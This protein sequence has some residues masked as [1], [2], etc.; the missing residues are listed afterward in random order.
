MFELLLSLSWAD[1]SDS[2]TAWPELA[3][4][5]VEQ[6]NAQDHAIV[7]SVED[8]A[9]VPDIRGANLNASDWQNYFSKLYG[10]PVSNITWLQDGEATK[11]KVQ[12]A[13]LS[14]VNKSTEEGKVWFVFIGHGAPAKDGKDGMLVLADVQQDPQSLYD[15]SLSQE[16]VVKSL[17]K[18]KQAQ[19]LLIVDA[20]FSG[21]L[22]GNKALAEGL[23]PLIATTDLYEGNTTVLSA[24]RHNEFAGPLPGALPY[25]DRPAFSYLTLGG[26]LGWA[27]SDNDGTVSVKETIDYSQEALGVTLVGRT[28]EP[29]LFGENGDL[30]LG[31]GFAQGPD[32]AEI[33]RMSKEIAVKRADLL[34]KGKDGAPMSIAPQAKYGLSIGGG[35][36][37]V[38]ASYYF[39][40]LAKDRAIQELN[41]QEDGEWSDLG[42]KGRNHLTA[43][44]VLTG[45]GVPILAYGVK[46]LF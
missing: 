6:S 31:Q 7:V 1:A 3:I 28:Q 22:E 12:A 45:V 35:I 9:Y 10:I 38:G 20:C 14:T 5:G 19:T 26:M 39:S 21:Q 32:L 37:M 4:E 24:G 8:Y 11:E 25:A 34:A 40:A 30:I 41:A 44:I 15:R 23:Q 2:G 46:S 42:E 16:W 13:V 17:E 43:S 33:Q 27:D 29:Q 36:V 18:G